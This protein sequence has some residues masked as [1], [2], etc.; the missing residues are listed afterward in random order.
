GDAVQSL[1][2]SPDGKR[3]ASGA[4]RSVRIWDPEAPGEAL[5]EITEPFLGRQTAL[6]FLA[7]NQRLLAADSLPSE[8]GRLHEIALDSKK[9]RSFDTAHRDSIFALA[10]SPDGKRYATTSA[11]K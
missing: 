6:L 10:L 7:D 1:A 4:F 5:F 3:L 2:F 9:V 11:D 8:I